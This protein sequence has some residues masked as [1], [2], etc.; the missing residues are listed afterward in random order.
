MGF[1]IAK[2]YPGFSD[3]VLVVRS[4]RKGGL[5]MDVHRWF[6]LDRCPVHFFAR[7]FKT[8]DAAEKA[9]RLL[10]DVGG[11]TDFSIFEIESKD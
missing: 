11:F 4:L 2:T 1:Y 8:R 7:Q 10:H 5:S 9:L 3:S 6:P